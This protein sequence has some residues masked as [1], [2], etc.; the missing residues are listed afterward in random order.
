MEIAH[1]VGLNAAESENK[2]E[3]LVK[4]DADIA[5]L[6]TQHGVMMDQ[7]QVDIATQVR[8]KAAKPQS[9]KAASA[10]PPPLCC[11]AAASCLLA[12]SVF[13]FFSLL[14]LTNSTDLPS[15]RYCRSLAPPPL[16]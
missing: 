16:L 13:L 2:A 5:S 10:P 8:R 7:V 9:R 3:A 12:I 14:R 1:Q 15:D 11:A 6:F 4:L